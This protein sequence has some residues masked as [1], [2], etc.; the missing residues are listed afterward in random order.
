MKKLR[1]INWYYL[2]GTLPFVASI[3]CMTVMLVNRGWLKIAA[4]A[5]GAGLLLWIIRKFRYLPRREA[6]YGDMKVCSLALPV[7]I[8]ADIYL[9][10]VMDRYE[11]LKRNVEILS[12][13]FKRPQ[14]NFKIAVSP[15]L[16]EQEGEKFTQIAVMREIIRYR[17]ASQVKASLGLVTPALLLVSL[18]E[19]YY[20]F[21]WNRIYPIAPGFLNFFGPLAAALTSIAFLLVWNKN[22]SRIDY[23]VDDELK[24]YYSK[25][26]IAA[27]IKRWDEL[28]LP[29]EPE[30]VNEKSRQLELYYRDQ[31]IERL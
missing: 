10:P 25:T 6:D 18:V 16:Y 23:Q 28:L 7:D 15:R 19:G 5:A 20:A 21:G 29:K 17:Q 11:F 2:V 31:R 22:M 9:C 3:T 27:Y 8:N 14:E 13:L 4:G 26:D 12:P 1:S 30:L 24:H